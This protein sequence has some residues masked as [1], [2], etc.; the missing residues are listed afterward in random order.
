VFQIS[1]VCKLGAI[2]YLEGLIS[3]VENNFFRFGV[4]RVLEK[5]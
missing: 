3:D 5:L 1:T 2:P 4:I